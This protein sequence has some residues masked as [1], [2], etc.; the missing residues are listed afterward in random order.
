V[1]DSALQARENLFFQ[2]AFAGLRRAQL[3]DR[4]TQSVALRNPDG[5]QYGPSL[6][7][8]AAFWPRCA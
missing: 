5:I 1:D 8:V 3:G 2:Q 6:T 7:L 4:K